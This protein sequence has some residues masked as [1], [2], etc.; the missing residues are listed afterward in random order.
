[1]LGFFGADVP[2]GLAGIR[3]RRP[4]SFPSAG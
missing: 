2:A 3:E 1:M 4:A